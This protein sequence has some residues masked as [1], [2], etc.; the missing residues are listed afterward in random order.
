VT[1]HV[2]V[3]EWPTGERA[4]LPFVSVHTIANGRITRWWDYW[5]LGTLMNGAPAWWV[6]HIMAESLRLGLRTDD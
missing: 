3:G 1:E 5:D 2:E 6:E 4:R